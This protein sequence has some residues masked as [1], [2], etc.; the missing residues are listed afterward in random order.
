MQTLSIAPSSTGTLQLAHSSLPDKQITS[1]FVSLSP[2]VLSLARFGGSLE[3]EQNFCSFFL[4]VGPQGSPVVGFMPYIMSCI[5]CPAFLALMSVTFR[6]LFGILR[7]HECFYI[8]FCQLCTCC[9][10]C[11]AR[12]VLVPSLTALFPGFDACSVMAHKG[13]GISEVVTPSH[14]EASGNSGEVASTSG[15]CV[16]AFDALWFCYSPG[17]QV[18][19]CS[20]SHR[21]SR[22][23]IFLF[24]AT[25]AISLISVY[26]VLSH[27]FT[28]P[29][30]IHVRLPL[31]SITLSNERRRVSELFRC[32]RSKTHDPMSIEGKKIE[33]AGRFAQVRA[34]HVWQFRTVEE[35]IEREKIKDQG[36]ANPSIVVGMK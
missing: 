31:S 16:D 34:S 10:T 29:M 19:L 4:H 3:T 33:Q 18:C 28:R 6:D 12:H 27:R 1:R 13:T 17:H 25:Q 8:D 23:P 32:M 24:V 26:P 7:D 11:R 21:M 36:G 14:G 15:S 5:A 22:S 20:L 9:R 35:I 30:H 2:P